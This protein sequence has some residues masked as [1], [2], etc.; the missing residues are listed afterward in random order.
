MGE[1]NI[2]SALNMSLGF[3]P[4][5]ITLVLCLMMPQDIAIY[6]G[7]GVGV[8]ATIVSWV[9]KGV[10]IPKFILSLSTILLLIFSLSSLLI[11]GY[12]PY[13][14]L[15]LTLEVFVFIIMAILFLHKK[16]F[17]N[18]LIR[19]QGS[20]TKHFYIQA[21]ESTVVSARIFL[22]V[23][24]THFVILGIMGI[25]S[26][27]IFSV[28]H[29]ILYHLLPPL[30][31]LITIIFNEIAI[32][33]FNRITTHIEYLP[34]VNMNGT[35]VGRTLSLDVLN[36][37]NEF[38]NPVIRIVASSKGKVYLCNRS[39]NCIIEQN[40]LDIPMECYLRYGETLE[41][42][43][44]RLLTNAFPKLKGE[45][46]IFNLVYHFENDL[47]NRLNYLFLIDAD[48]ENLIKNSSFK[49]GKLWSFDEVDE[50]IDKPLVSALLKQEYE[51]IKN[52]IYI[53]EK[54]KGL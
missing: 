48:N 7:A 47:T 53:R 42:G 1:K 19:R 10:R 8:L 11:K 14:Y 17:I 32:F 37:K 35:V 18:F 40:K 46:P 50:I 6:I 29:R 28:E 43:A 23:A 20:C 38:I 49:N 25:V 22:I 34:I 13:G 54:Y 5:L 36:Y 31:F 39:N 41:E 3:I 45:K 51:H 2:S 24:A 52:V 21:A 4:I 15:P 16:R 12:C 44:K 9:R 30:V 27:S 33:Y 26:G